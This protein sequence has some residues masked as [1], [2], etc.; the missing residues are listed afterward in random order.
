MFRSPSCPKKSIALLEDS[1]VSPNCPQQS[2]IKMQMSTEHWWND[3]ERG[4]PKYAEKHLPYCRFIHH[5]RAHELA[6]DSIVAANMTG[7]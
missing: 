5:K 2:G 3:N 7:L 1:Q 4:K 6:Y